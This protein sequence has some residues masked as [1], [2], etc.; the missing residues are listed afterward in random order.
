MTGHTT[1]TEYNVVVELAISAA[2]LD[3]VDD[4]LLDAFATH[5]PTAAGSLLDR[6][7]L[8]LTLTA[9]TLWEAT[10]QARELLTGREILSLRVLSAADYEKVAGLGWMPELLSVTEAA[11]RTGRSRTRIQQLIDAGELSA[12]KAG[13]TWL[14][15]ATSVEKWMEKQDLGTA[16]YDR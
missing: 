1:G 16:A 10:D 8:T 5:H 2:D 4:E 15:A 12:T 11:E 6:V 13:K 3:Q 9:A 7:E 14:I